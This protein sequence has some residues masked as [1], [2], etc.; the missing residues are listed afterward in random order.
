[1]MRTAARPGFTLVEIIVVLVIIAIATAFTLPAFLEPRADDDMTAAARRIDALFRLARDSAV[2]GGVPIAVALDSATGAVWLVPERVE[3]TA[4]P[5]DRSARAGERSATNSRPT[6]PRNAIGSLR[7][8]AA[9]AGASLELPA[10]V[11]LELSAARAGFLFTPG[12]AA[13]GDTLVLRT[14]TR[15][16]TITLDPWT[17]HVIAH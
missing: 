13:F 2:R 11:R 6:P 3:P 7:G 12:G 16:M 1:M 10:S 8:D 5:A 17:G 15:S 14:A 9:D 4:G